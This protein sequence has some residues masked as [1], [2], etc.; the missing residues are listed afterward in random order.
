VAKC[1]ESL[2]KKNILLLGHDFTNENVNCLEKGMID[3]L[4]CEKPEEQGYTGH[5]YTVSASCFFKGNG[6]DIPDA[7]RHHH[8]TQLPLLPELRVFAR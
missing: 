4:I 3:F 8:K 1:L 2:G 7:D 6:E 5:H